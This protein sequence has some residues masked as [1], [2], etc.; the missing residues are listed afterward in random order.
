MDHDRS[1]Q[2]GGEGGEGP[3][4]PDPADDALGSEAAADEARIVGRHDVACDLRGY[5]FETHP[6][7]QE[8]ANQAD[9]QGQQTSSQQ[10][11]EDGAQGVVH[12]AAV[13]RGVG[14]TGWNMWLGWKAYD[15]GRR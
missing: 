8:H 12:Q 4:V 7:R 10:Q 6:D 2:D 11:R 1:G 3:D 13:W 5:P 14:L 9:P 15:S